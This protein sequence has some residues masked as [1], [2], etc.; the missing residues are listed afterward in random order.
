MYHFNITP[1]VILLQCILQYEVRAVCR[2]AEAVNVDLL[3]KLMMHT[4][5]TFNL[6]K[7]LVMQ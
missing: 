1:K 6:F 5:S 4:I 7:C 3:L 2:G